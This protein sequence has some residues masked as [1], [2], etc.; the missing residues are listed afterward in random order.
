LVK[1]LKD[2]A[3]FDKILTPAANSAHA[4]HLHLELRLA[5]PSP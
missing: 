3:V 2:E 5:E 4:D 1:R